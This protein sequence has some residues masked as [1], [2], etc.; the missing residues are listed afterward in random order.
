MSV[1]ASATT[2]RDLVLNLVVRDIKTRYKQSILGYAWAFL[3]PLVYALIYVLI[4]SVFFRR[5]LP[6]SNNQP[7]LPFLI[8]SYYGILLWNLFAT[9]LASATEGLVSHMSLITKVYF[10][11]EVFPVS[12]VLSKIVDYGFGLIG[13][14]PL[15]LFVYFVPSFGVVTAPS[16]DIVLV[17]PILVLTLLF[18]MGVGMLCACANLFFRDVRYLVQLALN[19]GTFLV[20]NMYGLDLVKPH[21]ALYNIYLLNP[22]AVFIEA[23]RRA[24]FPQSGSVMELWPY[25]LVAAVLSVGVFF[26]GFAVFK[27]YEPLFAESI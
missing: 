5:V 13:L 10:P 8:H 23:S 16:F 11:R 26:A 2:H 12:A 7:G 24:T 3:N 17:A 20:P 15:L 21:G 18:T 4:G 14:I 19:L 25:L 22:M 1:A 9:G 27:K 6:G